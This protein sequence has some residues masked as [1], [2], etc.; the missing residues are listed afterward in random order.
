MIVENP[1]A[2][3]RRYVVQPQKLHGIRDF[4]MNSP[5]DVISHAINHEIGHMVFNKSMLEN[6]EEILKKLWREHAKSISQRTK[7]NE[8][9]FFAETF[10]IYEKGGIL[11]EDIKTFIGDIIK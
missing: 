2:A 3:Y 4:T 8:R 5:Q 11:D 10:A 1:K 7:F 9:E 6:K